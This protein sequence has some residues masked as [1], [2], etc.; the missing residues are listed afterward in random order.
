MHSSSHHLS[1][2]VHWLVLVHSGHLGQICTQVY[3]VDWTLVFK[4]NSTT[5]TLASLAWVE[6]PK[7]CLFYGSS[8]PLV[9]GVRGRWW[10]RLP[11]F[12]WQ[13]PVEFSKFP[14][15]RSQIST[16]PHFFYFLTGEKFRQKADLNIKFLKK[17][18]V[19]IIRFLFL[20][21]VSTP[22]WNI[23]KM[24]KALYLVHNTFRARFG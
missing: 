16:S 11:W 22:K 19:K 15:D 3:R 9:S 10:C 24:I 20:V 12:V 6:I 23:E 4:P 5:Y 18:K 13:N 21:W 1:A 8:L 14:W 2:W 7:P 17:Y